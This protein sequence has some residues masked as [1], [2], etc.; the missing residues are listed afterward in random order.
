MSAST[1]PP[2]TLGPFEPRMFV[3]D[4]MHLRLR[5]KRHQFRYGVFCVW[6]D[7]DRLEET[8]KKLRLFSIDR[9]GL[10]SFARRDHGPRDG[11]DLRPW[12]E[13]RL[14]EAGLA[15]PDRIMLLCFPRILGYVFNPL[16][17]Y[18][19]YD[20]AGSLTSVVYQVSNTFGDQHPYVIKVAENADGA[21]RHDQAKE[22][23]VSPFIDMDKTYRFTIRPPDSRL[24]VRIKE[25]DAV[26][27]YLIAT[28]NGD[29]EPLNDRRLAWRFA[30]HPLMTLKV[31]VGIHWEAL[32]LFLKG[33]RFLGHPGAG[34]VVKRRDDVASD[35]VPGE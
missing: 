14:A 22:F 5:P 15:K 21:A 4:V 3:G 9:F 10:A 32:R 12:V 17:V 34:N 35:I 2:E 25:S 1:H 26:G 7:V 23:F 13:A 16:S 6:L 18:Y 33:V 28:W 31:I 27:E 11:S 19:C 8:A 30:T 20:A 24:A 29:A